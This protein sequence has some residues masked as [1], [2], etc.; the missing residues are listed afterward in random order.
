MSGSVSVLLVRPLVAALGSSRLAEFWG[1]TDLTP[2]LI[3][4]D[5]A[6]VSP[7]QFCVAWAEAIRLAAR[8]QLALAIAEATPAGAF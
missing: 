5:D 2:Q 6:R 4:D 8:P 7:A 1:A 3:V